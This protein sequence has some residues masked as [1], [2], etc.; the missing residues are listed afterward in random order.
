MLGV[1]KVWSKL[2]VLTENKYVKITLSCKSMAQTYKSTHTENEFDDL[3]FTFSQ[4]YSLLTDTV[5]VWWEDNET[6]AC[7]C[8]GVGLVKGS[9]PDESLKYYHWIYFG[10]CCLPIEIMDYGTCHPKLYT[11]HGTLFPYHFSVIRFSLVSLVACHTHTYTLKWS[12]EHGEHLY[13]SLQSTEST[14]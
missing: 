13:S 4:L 5:I 10:D 2:Y 1:V 7:N 11:E 14:R 8:D 6:E 9:H 3:Q 12:T